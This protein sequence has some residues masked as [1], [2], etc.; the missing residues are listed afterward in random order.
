MEKLSFYPARFVFNQSR[1][2]TT[3]LHWD[4]NGVTYG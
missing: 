2:I 4:A 3:R 1:T